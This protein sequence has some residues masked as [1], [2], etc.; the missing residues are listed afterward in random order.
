LDTVITGHSGPFATP[1]CL[2]TAFN[3]LVI[4]GPRSLSTPRF[5][6]IG[7]HGL[8][9]RVTADSFSAIVESHSG[10]FAT[11]A[12]LSTAFNALVINGPRSLSTPRFT[13]IGRHGLVTRIAADSF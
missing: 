7:R 8:I 1:A 4:N 2:S 9:T 12:C 5:T 10:P 13:L 3:A 6:V 11:P